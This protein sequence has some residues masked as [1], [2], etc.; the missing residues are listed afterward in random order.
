MSSFEKASDAPT[1]SNDAEEEDQDRVSDQEDFNE[2]NDDEMEQIEVKSLFT[3]TRLLSINDLI[4]LDKQLFGFDLRSHVADYCT[5]DL[6]YI[7]L[8]NFIRRF[9]SSHLPVTRE[10]IELLDAELLK[11]EFLADD[12]NMR[13]VLED[14][15]LLFM[16]EEAFDLQYAEDS[17][18]IGVAPEPPTAPIEIEEEDSMGDSGV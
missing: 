9:V 2:W 16:Y 17:A 15:P 6:S 11:K 10:I 8:I 18:V 14:D 4:E 1:S 7:K 12:M 13:P 3:E 5:E